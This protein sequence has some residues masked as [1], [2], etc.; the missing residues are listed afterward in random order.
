MVRKRCG[1]FVPRGGLNM[2]AFKFRTLL[3]T[4]LGLALASAW[5]Y[6]VGRHHFGDAR[7]AEDKAFAYIPDT[8]SKPA[9]DYLRTFKDPANRPENPAP[10][11][12]AAWNRA[13]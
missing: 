12:L 7:A 9:Q 3:A 1:G 11:D 6:H 10:D 5:F 8:I 13:K 2:L 4:I